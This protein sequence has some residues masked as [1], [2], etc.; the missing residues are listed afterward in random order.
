MSG[1]SELWATS[2]VPPCLRFHFTLLVFFSIQNCGLPWYLQRK[3]LPVKQGKPVKSRVS[4]SFF[5]KQRPDLT[6][7][8]PTV[9]IIFNPEPT[10]SLLSEL[11]HRLSSA[12]KRSHH[13]QRRRPAQNPPWT[14][15]Q[16]A[17]DQRQVRNHPLP[18]PRERKLIS[19]STQMQNLQPGFSLGIQMKGR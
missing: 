1:I 8:L 6:L 17:R 5:G 2:L 12:A 9:R 13:R 10:C 15:G 7:S 14:A 11:T 4:C 18:S 16:K 19:I 3:A